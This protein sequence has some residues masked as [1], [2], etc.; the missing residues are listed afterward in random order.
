MN[1]GKEK[2]RDSTALLTRKLIVLQVPR[3]TAHDPIVCLAEFQAR[4]HARLDSAE[5][6]SSGEK[7]VKL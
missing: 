4:T 7:R 2:I 3:H 1:S 5:N 6:L